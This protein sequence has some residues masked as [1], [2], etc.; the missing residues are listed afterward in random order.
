MRYWCAK[1][2]TP[3]DGLTGY[4]YFMAETEEKAEEEAWDL[5]IENAYEWWDEESDECKDYDKENWI[6]EAYFELEEVTKEE[7]EQSRLYEG[8]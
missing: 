6:A 7:Y 2:E 3:S 8:V 4:A 5:C 1:L